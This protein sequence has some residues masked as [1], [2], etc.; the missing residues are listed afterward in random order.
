MIYCRQQEVFMPFA[1]LEK[2]IETLP[3]ATV[4]EVVDFIRFIK[5]K[6]STQ[7]ESST[8]TQMQRKSLY[9]IWKDEPFY[10]SPAFDEPLEDFAEY[11]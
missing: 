1:V 11:M 7:T 10:M 8:K 4:G 3:Q 5:T 2:E 9:G 6:F